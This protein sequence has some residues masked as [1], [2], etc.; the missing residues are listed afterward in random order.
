MVNIDKWK[1]EVPPV[2]MIGRLTGQDPTSL[3]SASW[4]KGRCDQI[5]LE[6]IKKVAHILG[7]DCLTQSPHHVYTYFGC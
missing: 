3:Q 5:I 6:P 1:I 7:V 2:S 4:K